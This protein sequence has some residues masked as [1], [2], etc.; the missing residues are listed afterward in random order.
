[1]RITPEPLPAECD[2]VRITQVFSNL[3]NNAVKYT[4]RG[5]SIAV[6]AEREGA[7]AI[8]RVRDTGVGIPAE[9][10]PRL[11]EMFYQADPA[12]DRPDG[13]LGIGLTLVHR[14]L[15]LHQGSVEAHSAGA[16]Q[17]SEF[18]VRLPLGEPLKRSSDQ[19]PLEA[20]ATVAPGALRL[21]VVDDNQD[22]AE[23]LRALLEACG[24]TVFTAFDGLAAIEVADAER[25]DAILLDIGLPGLNGYEVCRRLRSRDWCRDTLIVAQ[26]GWG[27]EQDRERSRDAG[28]DQHFTK[29]IDDEA[30]LTVLADWRRT[31]AS[32]REPLVTIDHPPEGR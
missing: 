19:P 14:L 8:V 13:G 31:R 30:L 29:P 15:E 3:L 2:V 5:G 24:N 16:G 12:L 28:F 11:F 18:V 10:L 22:S 4:P 6:I 7:T 26:T 32:D 20:V 25:P 9:Q 23:M 1:M 17:G 27:Q 21:L